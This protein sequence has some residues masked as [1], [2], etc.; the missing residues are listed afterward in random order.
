MV[1]RAHRSRRPAGRSL[2]SDR[3]SD[4]S[5]GDDRC[6]QPRLVAPGSPTRAEP[7]RATGRGP[8]RRAAPAGCDRRPA[9]HRPGGRCG[10]A[11]LPAARSAVRG[12][13]CCCTADSSSATICACRPRSSMTSKRS[14]WA[15]IRSSSS[16]VAAASAHSI[17]SNSARSAKAGPRHRPSASSRCG[18]GSGR[19]GGHHLPSPSRPGPR[20][21]SC[22]SRGRSRSST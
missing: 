11:R 9:A 10:T 15:L 8:A 1:R 22:P 7:G 18:D 19:I 4:R 3:G 13:G 12:S 14:S 17:S 5:G 6:R 21:P 16:R 2:C 20:R